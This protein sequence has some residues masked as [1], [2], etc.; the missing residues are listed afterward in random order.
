MQLFQKAIELDTRY[1]AAYAGLGEAYAYL[2]QYFER[3]E[4]WLDKAIESSLKAQLYDP[5]LSEAYAALGVAYFN[6]KM[7]DDALTAGKKAIELDLNNHIAYWI[8]GRIYR[9]IDRDTEAVALFKKV[10]ELNPDFYT[11][12]GDLRM[13]YE[14]L[15][16]KEKME[17]AL[18]EA[19]RIFPRYIL[20][21][22]DDARAHMLHAVTLVQAGRPA[23]EAKAAAAKAIELSPGDTVA[24]YNA[25]CFYA[26][27]GDKRLALNALKD[28][29]I[30]G[31]VDY[32]WIKRDPDFDSL[33]NEPLYIEL[34]KGK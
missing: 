23:E 22:P 7:L 27:L 3:K 19:I 25:A 29:I 33:R 30:S 8:L 5:T 15:G 6:K 14:R 1:A 32:E 16:Q 18:Q 13:T 24:M 4:L 12:Y 9:E 28:S 10:L 26:Q 2:Y 34:M 21:H 20:Q 17:E 11:G 31:W